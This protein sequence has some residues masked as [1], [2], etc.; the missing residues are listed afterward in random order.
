MIERFGM[1]R[2]FAESKAIVIHRDKYGVL[3]GT[4]VQ[5]EDEIVLIVRVKN[6]TPEPD[7]SFKEYFLRVPPD[8]TTAMAAVAWTFGMSEDEYHPEVET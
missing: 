1:A 4:S 8:I 7:G 6:R 3:Y 5:H 2:F